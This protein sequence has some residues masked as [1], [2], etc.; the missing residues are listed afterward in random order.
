MT[1]NYVI[2]IIIIEL[3]QQ[4]QR[5]DGRCTLFVIIVGD[6]YDNARIHIVRLSDTE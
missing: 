1:I 4:Q 5:L 6:G 3:Q 2:I